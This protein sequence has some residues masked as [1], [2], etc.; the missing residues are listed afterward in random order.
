[1]SEQTTEEAKLAGI[2]LSALDIDDVA[3]AEIQPDAPLFDPE[4][5]DSL[6]LDSID[7]LEI[8]LAI[9]QAYGVQLEADNED[10]R[11]IFFSLR[12]LNQY[13]L[14]HQQA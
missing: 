9:N 6:G 11:E 7:A 3:V 8:S 5:P 10:N 12:S 14:T 13:V 2:I 1:M 4:N